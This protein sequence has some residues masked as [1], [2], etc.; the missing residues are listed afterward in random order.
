MLWRVSLPQ[1]FAP[2]RQSGRSEWN[3]A[4]ALTVGAA[5]HF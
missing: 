4:A 2:Q 3:P 1:G 5:I